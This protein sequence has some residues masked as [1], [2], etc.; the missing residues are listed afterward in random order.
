LSHDPDL[1]DLLDPLAGMK[2][3]KGIK[4]IRI[5]QGLMVNQHKPAV[6]STPERHWR[7]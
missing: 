7:E 3:I 4:K 6:D 5:I 1:L 2:R